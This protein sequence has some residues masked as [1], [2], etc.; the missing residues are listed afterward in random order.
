MA[1]ESNLIKKGFNLY[2]KTTV[3][4]LILIVV[5]N[6]SIVRTPS[7]NY[8]Y[9][10]AGFAYSTVWVLDYIISQTIIRLA[11]KKIRITILRLLSPILLALVFLLISHMF[12]D[13]YKFGVY[14][15]CGFILAFI[16]F[17][18]NRKEN[19]QLKNDN[20]VTNIGNPVYS[21]DLKP[22]VLIQKIHVY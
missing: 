11:S 9:E 4:L 13:D 15:C 14:A 2:I 10:E 20:I 8:S 12:S 5:L 6:I 17:G 18:Q 3:A 16:I 22:I 21:I 1:K 19:F 7:V